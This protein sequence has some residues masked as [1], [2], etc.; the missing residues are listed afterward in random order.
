LPMLFLS[1]FFIHLNK[2]RERE[3]ENIHLINQTNK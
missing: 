1:L 2:E 3:R